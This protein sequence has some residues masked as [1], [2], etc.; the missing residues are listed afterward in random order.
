M[1]VVAAAILMLVPLGAYAG[2]KPTPPDFMVA[3]PIADYAPRGNH[4]VIAMAGLHAGLLSDSGLG[5]VR[6]RDL[7]YSITYW[8]NSASIEVSVEEVENPRWLLYEIE[9]AFRKRAVEWRDMSA[10]HG[11]HASTYT[12]GLK[13]FSGQRVFVSGTRDRSAGGTYAWISGANRV[14]QIL[15][16]EQV[17]LP[18][19]SYTMEEPPLAFLTTYLALLPS[20]LPDIHFDTEHERQYVRDEFDRDFEQFSH[21]LDQWKAHGAHTGEDEYAQVMGATLRIRDRRSQYF[22]GPSSAE[23]E[24]QLDKAAKTEAEARRY[25]SYDFLKSQHDELKTWW[26]HHRN[27]HFNVRAP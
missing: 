25:E 17:K 23:W 18:D 6:G 8:K 2:E 1:L 11:G 16:P 14:V 26:N 9:A 22:G 5:R 20:T 19:G 12:Y 7:S 10:R 3:K 4:P 15:F 24:R 21:Y 27:D 13:E